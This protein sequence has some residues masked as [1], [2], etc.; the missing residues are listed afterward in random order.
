MT[1]QKYWVAGLFLGSL[2]ACGGGGNAGTSP[3]GSNSGTTTAVDQA[4]QQVGG[5]T[6]AMSLSSRTVTAAAPVTVRALVTDTATGTPLASKIVSFTT[7]N[8]LGAFSAVSALTDASGYATVSLTPSASATGGADEAVAST[9]VNG[10]TV[11][12]TQAF[13]LTAS[14]VTIS[15]LSTSLAASLS[16]YGQTDVN[17]ALSGAAA[18]TPV[19]VVL[20]SGCVAKGKATISPAKSTTTTGVVNAV[21]KDLGCGA[22]DTAD[23]VQAVVTGSSSSRTLSIPLVSP[24]VN[25]ITFADATP[26]IIYLKGSGLGESAVVAFK[27]V[28]TSGNPLPN[29]DV[30]LSL[31]TAAGGVTMDQGTAPVT[32]KSDADGKVTVNINS[33]TVP[34]PVRVE[35]KLV[36]RNV[37]TVSSGLTVAVGLPSQLN[38]SLSQGTHNIEGYNYDGTPNTYTIIASDRSGNPVPAGTTINFVTEGG[39]VNSSKQI[40][41]DSNGVASATANFASSNPRPADGRITV[42]AYALGEESF[43]D[44]NGNNVWDSNEDFQDLGDV[45]KD[46]LFDGTYASDGSDEFVALSIAATGAC[47]APTSPLLSLDA[48]IPSRPAT[49]DG[50][51]GKAYVRRATETVLS[52]SSSGLLWTWASGAPSANATDSSCTTRSLQTAPSGPGVT[53]YPVSGTAL[54]DLPIQGVFSILV[55]DANP[56]RLNPM[57]MGTTLSVKTTDGLSATFLGGDK[58]PDSLDVTAATMSYKFGDTTMEGSITVTTTSP[59]GL[60]MSTTFYVSRN[61]IPS[62]SCAK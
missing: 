25:S 62:A 39:Q 4:S 24:S 12:A 43:H 40:V 6:I 35:A 34:T 55:A 8:G 45:F 27:V 61:A 28:D 16:A 30:T 50:T 29:Q 20:S 54:Y 17:V 49:C 33:G 56:V 36:S 2:A 57:A 53:F 7:T 11:R 1:L 46:R 13:Q 21:Y 59:R 32:K 3:F 44:S 42:T 18:G 51:W 26:S 52:T 15:S 47:K 60:A 38:F 22:T 41:I 23:T 37:S 58:V 19:E 31:V 10:G 14:S 9:T 48:S 5:A